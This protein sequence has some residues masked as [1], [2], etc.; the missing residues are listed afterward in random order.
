LISEDQDHK[1][2]TALEVKHKMAKA[3]TAH[4][5]GDRP[6][7]AGELA[8]RSGVAVST[9]HFYEAKGLIQG[10][11]SAG[12]QRRYTRDVLRRVAIIKVAQRLGLPL[13]TIKQAIDS[14]PSGRTPTVKDWKRL[15]AAW[16]K[17]LDRRIDLLQRLRGEL[18]GCIGC[19]CLSLKTCQLRNP[20]DALSGQGP[21]PQLL[22]KGT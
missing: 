10:W 7:S 16:R 20:G 18:D 6:L 12:N 22:E 2:S 13:A 14:L 5:T 15:S 9:I 1:T 21:G 4:P 11:R 3:G 8:A 17:E 19:G